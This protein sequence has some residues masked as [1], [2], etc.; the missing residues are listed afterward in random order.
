MNPAQIISA[1]LLTLLLL[2]PAD[3]APLRVACYGDSILANVRPTDPCTL[4]QALRPDIAVI[5]W[6]Q[7]GLSTQAGID[8][9]DAFER[10]HGSFSYVITNLAIN[11]PA[12]MGETDPKATAQRIRTL[13][14]KIRDHG[15]REII[16]T[17]TPATTTAT[18]P[19]GPV[20]LV[21][22]T[23]DV[24]MWLYRLNGGGTAYDVY[25][26]RDIFTVPGW[27]RC[28]APTDRTHPV[29]ACRAEIAAYLATVVPRAQP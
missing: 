20:D 5:Q 7:G 29:E 18:T 12:Q 22:F 14:G 9:Y 16:L 19:G 17:P 13:A 6:S 10:T 28:T 4:L 26:M 25:D 3:A 24:R 27:Q 2:T 11:D 1:A 21:A 23:R 15:A 8:E